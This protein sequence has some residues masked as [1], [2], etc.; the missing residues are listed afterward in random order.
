MLVCGCCVCFSLITNGRGK[1]TRSGLRSSHII[2]FSHFF[3]TLQY[4]GA[5]LIRNPLY[6]LSMIM[7]ADQYIESREVIDFYKTPALDIV[8]PTD[9]GQVTSEQFMLHLG[10]GLCFSDV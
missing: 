10:N 2:S 7:K 6:S 9:R 4:H 1:F 5:T 3:D 8:G